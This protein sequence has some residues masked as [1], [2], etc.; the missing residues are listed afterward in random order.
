MMKTYISYSFAVII[1]V[2]N[3]AIQNWNL[4]PGID[5]EMFLVDWSLILTEVAQ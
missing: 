5:G 2:T 1:N 3:S 4:P